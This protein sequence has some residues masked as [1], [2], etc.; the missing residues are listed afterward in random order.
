MSGDAAS[1]ARAGCAARIKLRAT[2]P[3]SK[4]PPRHFGYATCIADEKILDARLTGALRR[5]PYCRLR[6]YCNGHPF[7]TIRTTLLAAFLGVGL[8]PAI[9]LTTLAFIKA[10]QALQ[11]EIERNMSAED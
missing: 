10:R 8:L 5:S 11:E 7:V 3:G 6:R 9:V 1:S 2:K 4:S